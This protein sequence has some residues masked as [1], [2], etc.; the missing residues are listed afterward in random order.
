[1]PKTKYDDPIS[2]NLSRNYDGVYILLTLVCV[3]LVG[4]FQPT[5]EL[6]GLHLPV[7]ALGG[8]ACGTSYA[9][10][11]ADFTVNLTGYKYDID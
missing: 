2:Y 11:M 1:M 7:E 5:V 4:L 3:Y 10:G 9:T 8:L 6:E